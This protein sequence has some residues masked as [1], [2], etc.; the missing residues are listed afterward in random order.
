MYCPRCGSP[1]EPQDRFCASCGATL[2]D[3]R[4]AGETGAKSQGLSRLIGAER[5]T[6][7]ITMLTAIAIAVAV[8]AFLTISPDEESIPRDGYTLSAEGICLNAKRQIVEAANDGS[9]DFAR[10]L[11]PIVVRWREQLDELK[12][13]PDRVGEVAALD[14]ALREMEIE[15]GGLARKSEEEARAV[16]LTGAQ[17]AEAASAEVENAVGAL[18]LSECAAAR[19]EFR[20]DKG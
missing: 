6:R 15:A 8:V 12:P 18:G 16:I 1:N 13:P 20:P 14:E 19:I 10:R 4:R 2:R 11:V 7:V 9:G 17:R 3:S 5:K